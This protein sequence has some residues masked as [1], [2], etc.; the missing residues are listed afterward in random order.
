MWHV[1]KYMQ[2]CTLCCL[3]VLTLMEKLFSYYWMQ[4]PVAAAELFVAGYYGCPDDFALCTAV[5]VLHGR[6]TPDGQRLIEG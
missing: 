3:A 4:Q 5:G 2:Q 1:S 6:L